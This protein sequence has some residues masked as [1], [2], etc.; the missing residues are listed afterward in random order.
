VPLLPPL[1]ADPESIIRQHLATQLLPMALTCM[2]VDEKQNYNERGYQVVMSH[3]VQT[4]L[5]TLVQDPDPDVRRAA[6]ESLSSL[7]S[8][9][10]SE[11]VAPILLP[12]PLRMAQISPDPKKNSPFTEDLKI[13][14]AN[15]LGE[16]GATLG[17]DVVSQFA[18]PAILKFAQDDVSFRVRRAAVQALPRILGGCTPDEAK[19]LILPAFSKLAQDDMYRVRKAAGECLVDMSRSLMLVAHNAVPDNNEE[20]KREMRKMRR[21]K[22]IPICQALLTDANKFVRHGMMQF[23]GPFVASFYP[24]NKHHQNNN[25]GEN[26]IAIM[27]GDSSPVKNSKTINLKESTLAGSGGNGSGGIGA[28]FFP[29]ASSMVSRLNSSFAAN[30]SATPT[31]VA[32]GGFGPPA[33]QPKRSEYETLIYSL[34]DFI[35]SQRRAMTSLH[36]VLQHRDSRPPDPADL[37]AIQKHL[38]HHFCSLA[39][40]ST[41]DE[42][43]DAEMRVYCAY[44][45]PASIVLL[46]GREH[47]SGP[48]HNCFLALVNPSTT[49]ADTTAQLPP[50][51]PVKRCLASSLHTVAHILGPKITETDLLP[52]FVQHFFRDN[53]ESVRL[54]VIRH[55]PSLLSLLESPRS[56][57][58]ELWAQVVKAE[59]LL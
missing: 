45:F 49:E 55:F 44:S 56:K 43:S 35:L 33:N 36:A 13:T 46:L 3:I 28:Q 41:G 11:D 1:V 22:L 8:H 26:D 57:Y 42:G 52:V 24:L 53:D 2:Y 18:A 20:V 51:L 40:I 7:A 10:K 4:S 5:S 38:L 17:K 29:H 9:V 12:I 15:L 31:P 47:W 27:M 25:T 59:D 19:D 30:T 16:L 32:A 21:T 48:L 50:P 39:R 34:P 14:A 6:S 23:L 58:L 37:E 54:N